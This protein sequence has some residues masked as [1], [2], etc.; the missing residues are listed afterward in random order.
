M[1]RLLAYPFV[2]TIVGWNII[3][4]CIGFFIPQLN[5]LFALTYPAFAKSALGAVIVDFLRLFT[6][7]FVHSGWLHLSVNMIWLIFF[8]V[9]L[10]SI[11]SNRKLMLTYFVSG[12]IGGGFFLLAAN[13]W[14]SPGFLYLIGSSSAVLG[15]A[16]GTCILVPKQ[17]LNIAGLRRIPIYAISILVILTILVF[18]SD[19]YSFLAHIG[20]IAG[21]AAISFII[22]RPY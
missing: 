22:K 15:L 5:D 14:E 8:G 21:G 10:Q 4:A 11:L 9:L 12:A 7:T 2:V 16:T 18:S 1:N 13:L 6:Y 17:K 19:Y 20:G 3:I